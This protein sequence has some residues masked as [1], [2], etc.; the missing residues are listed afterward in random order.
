[1]LILDMAHKVAAH[2]SKRDTMFFSPHVGRVASIT[3]ANIT[4]AKNG[5]LKVSM[6]WM[7]LTADKEQESHP[8]TGSN[9]HLALFDR[10]HG[11]NSSN[12]TELLR[13]T[14]CIKELE[15]KVNTEAVEQLHA[16]FNKKNIL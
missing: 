12:D 11:T 13:Y 2:A 8:A 10:F 14:D 16:S 5:T 1:M 3:D 7:S 9:A 15:G 6:P 4:A